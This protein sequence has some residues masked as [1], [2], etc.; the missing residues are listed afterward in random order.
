MRAPGGRLRQKYTF[1]EFENLWRGDPQRYSYIPM[2]HAVHSL[3]MD[4]PSVSMLIDKGILESFEVGDET[5]AQNI[6]AVTVQS[7]LQFKAAKEAP[8]HHRPSQILAKLMEAA[9]NKQTLGF[10]DVMEAVGLS[11]ADAAERRMFTRDVREAVRQ[12]ELFAR[13]LLISALLVFRTQ[14]IAEDDFFLMAKELGMFTPGKDSKT[15]FFRDHLERIFQ[16]YENAGNST[17]TPE[18]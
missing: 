3:R 13:G 5:C 17:G 11:Y 2:Q 10:G 1:T 14:H 16:F 18:K 7:L 4:R 15:V 6:V 8:S 12:S 9:R